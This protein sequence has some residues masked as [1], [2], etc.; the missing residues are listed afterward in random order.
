MGSRE[1]AAAQSHSQL[2][3]IEAAVPLSAAKRLDNQVR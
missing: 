1:V 3:Q 2:A